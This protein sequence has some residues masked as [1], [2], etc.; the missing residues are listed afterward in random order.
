ML[1]RGVAGIGVEVK[2]LDGS[3]MGGVFQVC[4]IVVKCPEYRVA[5]TVLE[6][7]LGF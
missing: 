2:G 4:Q 7:G 6:I 3:F 1:V 5:E